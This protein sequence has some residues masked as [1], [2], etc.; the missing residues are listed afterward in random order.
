MK[1]SSIVFIGFGVIALL[2]LFLLMKPETLESPP[3]APAAT[4]I[5]TVQS[6][7][8]AEQQPPAPAPQPRVFELVVK[9][10]ERTAGP[11]AMQVREGEDVAIRVISDQPDELHLHGYDLHADLK[12]NEPAVLYFKATHSGRFDLELHHAHLELGTLEVTPR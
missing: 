5:V 4:R 9:H 12:A 8:P 7:A 3:P 11:V 6:H 2:G 1:S 10:G